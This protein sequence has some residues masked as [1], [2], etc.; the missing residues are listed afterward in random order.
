MKL[1]AVIPVTSP[2][3]VESHIATRETL[4]NAA[5]QLFSEQGI[6]GTSVRD[7]TRAAGAN[8]GAINYHFGSKDRLA[9]E[10][11]ARC[12]KPLNC[13]RMARLD[14]LEA[15]PQGPRL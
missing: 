3:Q 6:E 9:L 2:L 15:G 14:A 4:L 8:L 11:F 7:I 10:V 13:E 5:E 1:S 12:L